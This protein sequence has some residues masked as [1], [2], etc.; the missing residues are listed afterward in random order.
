MALELCE[1]E[2]DTLQ[3][4]LGSLEASRQ[5][6]RDLQRGAFTEARRF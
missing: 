4:A 3:E 5:S 2:F 1:S 6:L